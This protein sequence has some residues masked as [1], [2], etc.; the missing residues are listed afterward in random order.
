M[1]PILIQLGT[2]RIPTYGFLFALGVLL[3]ALYS[4]RRARQQGL[5]AQRFGDFIFYLLLSSLVGAKVLLVVTNLGYYRRFPGEIRHLLTSGGTF[6]GGLIFG[7]G[8]AAWYI[9]R[10]RLSFPV[11]ADVLA[12]GLALGHFFGRLGCFFAGCCWGRSAEGCAAGVHFTNPQAHDLTGVPLFITLYPTQLA[13]AA[14]NLANFVFL[15]WLFRHRRFT[16]QVF[17]AYI[18]VYSAI[19]IVVEYFRGDPD[20]GYIIGG[21]DHPWTSLSV[22]QSISLLGFALGGILLWKFR[23]NREPHPSDRSGS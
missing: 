1:H 15:H 8:F 5:D 11:L 6:Y 16:G 10:H 17:I 14:L 18:W 3:A 23:K 12:P 13:E 21:L 22:S 9:R 4:T 19:R 7:I 2:I 20:R